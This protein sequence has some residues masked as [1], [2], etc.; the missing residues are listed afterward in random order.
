MANDTVQRYSK[1]K[2]YESIPRALLQDSGLSLAALGLLVNMQSY[3]EN[4][5]LRK[6][7]LRKRFKKQRPSA[8]NPDKMISIDA[9]KTIDSLWNELVEFNYILQFRKREGRSYSY[10]YFFSVEPFTSDDVQE[11][12]LQNFADHYMLYHRDMKQEKFN[13]Q[14]LTK[15]IFCENKDKIDCGFWTSLKGNSNE[16]DENVVESTFRGVPPVEVPQRE[17]SRLTNK[18][19]NYKDNNK[20]NI[21]NEREKIKFNQI[22]SQDNQIGHIVKFLYGTGLD[23]N[24]VKD[25][26]LQLDTKPYLAIPELVVE[27]VRLNDVISKQGKMINYASYFIGG[28]SMRYH[29]YSSNVSLENVDEYYSNALGQDFNSIEIPMMTGDQFF[30]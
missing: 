18:E 21:Y 5:V 1:H 6:T 2:G 17:H 26:A 24:I 15:Y 20:N 3:S 22:I 16:K 8:N 13:V 9:E 30:R 25:I 4:W 10:R 11:L 23:I 27:Q 14:D 7:E 28:L 12:L 19:I 29:S